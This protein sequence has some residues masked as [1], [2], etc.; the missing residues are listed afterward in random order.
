M[1][2]LATISGLSAKTAMAANVETL[3]MP[4]KLTASHAKFEEDCA[5]CHDKTDRM[6]QTPLCLDCHKEIAKDIATKRGAHGHMSNAAKGQCR[7]CHADH[8]GRDGD[9]VNFNRSDFD[10]SMTD[11]NLTGAHVGL[12]CEACHKKNEKYRKADVSCVSC[13]RG[14]DVHKGSLGETCA[15]CHDS[16][17]WN[18]VHFDHDKTDFPLRDA[19]TKIECN[20]CHFGPRYK[21][22]PKRCGDC[23]ATDDVHKGERGDDCGKCHTQA[24]WKTAK[25]DHLKETG[26][27]L[28]GAHLDIT[29][30]ACHTTGNFKDKVPKDC[31]GCHLAQDSHAGRFGTDCK[32]CHGEVKWKPVDY[33]HLKLTKFAL[34]GAHVKLE[35]HICHTSDVEKQKLG[36]ECADCH[37]AQDPHGGTLGK[38][39]DQCHNND[40]WHGP[41]RFD[42][43]LTDY[44]LLGQHVLASCAQCH[45]SLS[46]KDTAK[47]C[48]ACHRSQDVHKGGLGDDCSP[49]HS[50]NGW[51]L[52]EFDHAK[53]TGFA[54]TGA[55]RKLTCADCHREPPKKVKLSADCASCHEKDD[56]HVGEFGRQC[57]RCHTTISFAAA[58][59]H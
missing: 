33:D 8:K 1:T 35:C 3:L 12:A 24:S 4:G 52:W 55:H 43:D 25:F 10:H 44:P 54:L 46:F 34:I 39:C 18:S 50:S 23:H 38:A 19:H 29:C 37:K 7:A 53:E 9:I 48:V 27:P 22:T 14:Q 41:V 36:T 30:N 45:A 17:A 57:Q 6:Q 13:H 20:S 47:D 32:S 56:V 40:T 42:H 11:F 21:G 28:N 15:T 49:C 16:S 26:F 5:V 31:H 51:R 2:V 59:I 58:R